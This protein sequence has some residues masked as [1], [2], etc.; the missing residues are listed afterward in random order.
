MPDHAR[1]LAQDISPSSREPE[2]E[3]FVRK[4]WTALVKL[5]N[6]ES[7]EVADGRRLL[8]LPPPRS[9]R[10]KIPFPAR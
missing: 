7:T 5:R 6:R 8:R 4:Y 10:N 3:D 1:Q 9:M 2:S